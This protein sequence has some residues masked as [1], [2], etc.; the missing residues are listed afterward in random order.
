MP[1]RS[2]ILNAAY[3]GDDW[4]PLL[5]EAAIGGIILGISGL[6]FYANMVGTVLSKKTLT[7]PIE[8]PVAEPYHDDP[9]PGWLDSWKPWIATAIVLILIAYGPVLYDMITNIN[10]TSPGFSNLWG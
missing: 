5:I 6:L 1:R 7:E 9:I 8:M 2:M 3:I 4:N 10:N